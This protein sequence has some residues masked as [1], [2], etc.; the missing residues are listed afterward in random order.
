MKQLSGD[1][2]LFQHGWSCFLLQLSE[3][4]KLVIDSV[5]AAVITL[6]EP[7]KA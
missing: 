7:A 5:I 3:P 1:Q 2:C 4:I 6:L